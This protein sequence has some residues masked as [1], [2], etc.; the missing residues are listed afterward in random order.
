MVALLIADPPTLNSI[1]RESPLI[2]DPPLTYFS[3]LIAEQNLGGDFYLLCTT[4]CTLLQYLLPMIP[5]NVLK[6]SPS[7]AF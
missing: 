2:S 5:K 4:C 1:S 7:L 3:E 6:I